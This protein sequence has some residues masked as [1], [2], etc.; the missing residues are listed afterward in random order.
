MGFSDSRQPQNESC[1]KKSKCYNK[2]VTKDGIDVIIDLTSMAYSAYG[3]QVMVSE[4]LIVS[5]VRKKKLL[6]LETGDLIQG[7]DPKNR[8]LVLE[9]R[10]P[11]N[12]Y[13]LCLH[14]GTG[15]ET[16]KKYVNICWKW[17]QRSS[18][19]RSDAK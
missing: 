13:V 2:L 5:Q 19:I 6:T 9:S 17:M 15:T 8:F 16:E 10:Q 7:E 14:I 3:R 18:I 11:D 12:L 4:S 1:T